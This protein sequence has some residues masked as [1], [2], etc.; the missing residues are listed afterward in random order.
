M[1]NQIQKINRKIDELLFKA[2]DYLIKDEELS[3]KTVDVLSN[4]E[5]INDNFDVTQQ[6]K[7]SQI[8]DQQQSLNLYKNKSKLINKSTEVEPNLG[9][10]RKSKSQLLSDRKSNKKICENKENYNYI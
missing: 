1:G 6:Q 3:D 8:E 5:N 10:K 4:D 9:S 2:Y 7:E